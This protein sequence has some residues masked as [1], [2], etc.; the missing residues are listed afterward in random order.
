MEIIVQSVAVDLDEI[1]LDLNV[2]GYALIRSEANP[3]SLTEAAVRFGAH[4]GAAWVGV[5]VLEAHGSQEWLPRHTEQLDDPE[6]LRYFALGCLSASASGGA[7]CLYDGRIAAR[8]LLESRPEM[9]QVRIA[10]STAWRPTSATQ[11]LIVE[12][13]EHGLAL[14]FRSALETNTVCGPLPPSLS[15]AAMYTEVE[16][17]LSE[18]IAVVHRWRPGDL[19]VVDNRA[20][21]HAREPFTGARRMIR[22]RYDDPHFRTVIIAR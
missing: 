15:E 1:V 2:R 21:I 17:A 9:A 4:V 13:P 14:R 18:A 6:P 16:A 12:T 20:M 8:A 5:R 19:L 3:H 22:Y 7:T 10:Y 11:P